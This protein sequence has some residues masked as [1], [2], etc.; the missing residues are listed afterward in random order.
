MRRAPI[1]RVLLGVATAAVLGLALWAGR[2]GHTPAVDVP[3]ADGR[4]V[5]DPTPD[6]P[7]RGGTPGRNM[8]NLAARNITAV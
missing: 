7:M 4:A 5:L 3:R 6:W 2:A 1:R 8:V